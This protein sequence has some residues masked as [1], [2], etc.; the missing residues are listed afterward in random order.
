MEKKYR[1]ILFTN[2]ESKNMNRAQIPTEIE[3]AKF[4]F[5]YNKKILVESFNHVRYIFI[6]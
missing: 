5:Y 1:N 4:L 2:S 3:F 6:D